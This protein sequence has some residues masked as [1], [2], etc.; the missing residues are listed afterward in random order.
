[1]INKI[2]RKMLLTQIVSSMT[3]MLCMLIDSIMIGKF[4][5]VDSMTAY[6][7]AAPVL[8]VFAAVGSMISAGVQV[9][10]GR[11]M[12]AG[13]KKG[14]NACFSM[15]VFLVALISV[16]GL[17]V[18][19]GFTDP[20]CTLL[21][22]GRASP[23]NEVFYLTRDYL[24]GFIIGAPAFLAAQMMVPY[25]Q[26]SGNRTRLVVA[27]AAMTVGDILI[28]LLN[29]FVF[30]GGT[31][32]MGLASS[33]SYFIAFGIGLVYFFKK[34]CIFKFKFNLISFPVLKRLIIDGVPT[35]INQVSLV[36]LTYIFNKILL[37]VGGNVT[38]A[39][40]S[41]ISSAGNICYSFSAGIAAVSLML[42]A[43]LYSDQERTALVSLV[44][45][46]IFYS[47]IICGTVT[48]IVFAAARPL[49]NLFLNDPTAESYAVT[50]MRFF[51]L[52]LVPCAFNTCFKN[53]YQ[54]IDHTRFTCTIS[55]AQNLVFPAA[56]AFVL[57]SFMGVNGVWLSFLC[58]EILALTMIAIIVTVINKKPAL[59]AESFSLLPENFGTEDA[60]CFEF[61]VAN[62]ED[63][64]A[65]SAQA[66]H[67]CRESG[68]D[69]R[70]SKI[71][72][73]CIEELAGN[74]VKHGMANEEKEHSMDIRMVIK[75]EETI[76]RFRDNCRYF[77]PVKFLELHQNDN[78]TEHI[79]L[80]MI[81]MIVKDARY[82]NSL[83]LN[84][85]TLVI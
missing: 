61:S 27:V 15:S 9:M 59:N 39:A 67:A 73:L 56:S 82:V 65:A 35:L 13:D 5:G 85:L 60:F 44:R 14:T 25:M 24:R 45:S 63:V 12:G 4:L 20:I 49:V 22:A 47:F 83:G 11:T 31:F 30:K 23:D 50:G 10:C 6:G 66:E 2:F 41:V 68:C 17:I 38:V 33:V 32:G 62:S 48:V 7:L 75:K 70:S 52:S 69:D 84:N 58:G 77:D 37:E 34:K 76:L 26:I 29:V 64:S 81:M 78:P 71:I 74:V 72:A 16:I 8:L 18:V 57:S 79:G 28:D 51:V 36:F 80:R 1:M 19:L 40:Y 21:G 53:Y 42:S 3:V 55:I 46:M 54:G 43:V